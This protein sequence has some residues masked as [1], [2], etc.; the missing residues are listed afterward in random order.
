MT[1]EDKLYFAAICLQQRLQLYAPIDTGNLMFNGIL[2]VQKVNPNRFDVIIGGGVVDYA[3][4]TNEKGK[5]AG[6]V[7]RGIESALPTMRLIIGTVWSEQ[8]VEPIIGQQSQQVQ[9]KALDRLKAIQAQQG[10]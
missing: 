7:T 3:V 2:P 6:W 8:E 9:Q 10:V 1:V 5:H 4:A